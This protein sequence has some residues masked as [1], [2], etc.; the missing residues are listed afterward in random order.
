[1]S[2]TFPVSVTGFRRSRFSSFVHLRD[3]AGFAQTYSFVIFESRLAQKFIAVLAEPP[4]RG[5]Y[6]GWAVRKMQCQSGHRGGTPHAGKIDLLRQ[7]HRRDL[8][9]VDGLLWRQYRAGRQRRGMALGD[10]IV[11]CAGS[12]P[13]RA[14][15]LTGAAALAFDQCGPPRR[16]LIHVRGCGIDWP[17]GRG[18]DRRCT[19]QWLPDTIETTLPASGPRSPHEL[20]LARITTGLTSHGRVSSRPRRCRSAAARLAPPRAL[21]APRATTSRPG[22]AEV[23]T[24]TGLVHVACKKT[25]PSPEAVT[26]AI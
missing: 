3:D 19:G 20:W 11:A 22:I 23:D 12:S 24:N 13:C 10:G 5:A 18:A 4:R 26:G 21:A 1:L 7:A 9:I 14:D 6:F 8:G 15:F 2:F 25:P 17:A 16:R